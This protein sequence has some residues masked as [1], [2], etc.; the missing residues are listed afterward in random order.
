MKDEAAPS[1]ASRG[2]AGCVVS[3]FILASRSDEMESLWATR[4]ER[5]IDAG[6]ERGEAGAV[7]H[8][9]GEEV[10]IREVFGCG[11]GGKGE[12]IGQRQVVGPEIVAGIGDDAVERKARVLRG[13]TATSGADPSHDAQKGIFGQRAGGPPLPD[14]DILHETEG[15][16]VMRMV[17]VSE[18][19]QHVCIEQ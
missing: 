6:V 13:H 9:E 8:G 16:G 19:K 2:R 17:L 3:L 5:G 15:G 18:G 7:L 10:N 11:Q 4:N 14:G 12:G 1:G